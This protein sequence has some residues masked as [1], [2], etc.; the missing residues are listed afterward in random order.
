MPK[1]EVEKKLASI[2]LKRLSIDF[3]QD[4]D[5][6]KAKILSIS[7]ITASELLHV[8]FDVK[9][10]FNISIPEGDILKGRFD[11]FAS[12]VDIIDKQLQT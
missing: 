2:F 4:S 10:T 11:T 3:L 5:M 9:K 12:I 8:Y 7:G 1:H 6:R